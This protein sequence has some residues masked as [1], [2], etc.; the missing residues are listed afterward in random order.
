MCMRDVHS[1]ERAPGAA[2]SRRGHAG[3]P[4]GAT[5]EYYSGDRLP[6]FGV[7]CFLIGIDAFRA[8]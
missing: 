3:S 2:D 1:A 7:E 6:L 5:R 8:F 4:S